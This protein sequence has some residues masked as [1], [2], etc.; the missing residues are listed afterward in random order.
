MTDEQR[1]NV[2]KALGKAD[3]SKEIGGATDVQGAPTPNDPQ[4]VDKAREIGQNLRNK[5]LILDK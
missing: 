2:D 5:E 4:S 1:A 3:I